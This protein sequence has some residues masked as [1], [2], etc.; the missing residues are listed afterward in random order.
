[1]LDTHADG[2]YGGTGQTYPWTAVRAVAS[3]AMLAGGLTSVNVAEAIRT[4]RP[5]AVDVSSGVERDRVKDPDLI[6][7]FISEVRRVDV[8]RG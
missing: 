2:Q 5:W 3:E 4:A 1:M 7:A 6:R 8:D